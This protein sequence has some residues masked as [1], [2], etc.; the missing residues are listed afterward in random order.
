[1]QKIFSTPPYPTKHPRRV[2]SLSFIHQLRV[3]SSA[4]MTPTQPTQTPATQPNNAE[5][6]G[7]TDEYKDV[8]VRLLCIQG[9]LPKV[10]LLESDGQNS[11]VF[12]RLPTVD[13][14]FGVKTPR[15]SGR[16]F[17]IWYKGLNVLLQDTSTNGTYLNGI[18][19]TKGQ[20]YVLAHGDEISVGVGVEADTLKYLVV[21]PKREQKAIQDEDVDTIHHHYVIDDA[22]IGQGAFATVKKAIE[23]STG[24]TYAVKIVSKRKLGFDSKNGVKREMDILGQLDHP[25]IVR[26][27]LCYEDEDHYYLVMEFVPGGDL[28][29]LVAA[30]GAILED[31]GKEIMRQ[32]LEAVDY[33]HGR[34]IS[35]RDLKPDN[36]LI[37]S[38][39]PVVIKVTDF[40]LAKGGASNNDILNPADP[41]SLLKTFCGTLAYL[42]PEVIIGKAMLRNKSSRKLYLALVDMWSVGCLCYVILTGHWPF[43]GKTQEKLCARIKSGAYHDSPL[44]EC[45]LSDEAK[46]FIDLLL[47]TDPSKRLTAQE[48]L[49]HPWIKPVKFE[50]FSQVSLRLDSDS[51]GSKLA[52]PF[53]AKCGLS[54]N[55]IRADLSDPIE[56]ENR[57]SS[58]ASMAPPGTLLTLKP[59]QKS[60]KCPRIHV[61][62][63]KKPFLIGRSPECDYTY[64]DNRLSKFHCAIMR[65]RHAVGKSFYENPAQGLDDVWLIDYSTNG[66]H[67]NGKLIG[68]GK[69][70]LLKEGDQVLMFLDSKR[71]KFLGFKVYF[72]DTTGLFVESKSLKE[73]HFNTTTIELQDDYEATLVPRAIIPKRM[74]SKMSIDKPE[75]DEILQESEVEVNDK[76][77][78]MLL[79]E[80]SQ[81]KKRA[82]LNTSKRPDGEKAFI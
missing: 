24:D 50:S 61:P 70:T 49:S 29:G 40:G 30:Q 2:E 66:C 21:L 48:A 23:R 45:N 5:I 59:L 34:N 31:I 22:I 10:D 63:S 19:M 16:H 25:N 58:A 57:T 42:A 8:V 17:K 4:Q 78:K 72:K 68:K 35:H 67:I 12:G 60:I 14:P 82:V 76:K 65:K 27:H 54:D 3:S 39:E 9:G 13:R 18:R 46:S 41:G 20:N 38:A 75:I 33:I 47:Q 52:S 26:L 36:V 79:M 55:T 7:A 73:G 69:K 56:I 74:E 1:M 11:W 77:R 62:L 81:T 43:S 15:L 6:N 51:S 28:M 32:I 71:R 80:S 37:A 44:N 53:E 64:E